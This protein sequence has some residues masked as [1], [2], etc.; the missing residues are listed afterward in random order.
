M[1]VRPTARRIAGS[2][3]DL[4]PFIRI[5]SVLRIPANLVTQFIALIVAVVRWLLSVDPNSKEQS[6]GD[7]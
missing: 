4:W 7:D 1:Q 6:D 5:K 3:P 2:P